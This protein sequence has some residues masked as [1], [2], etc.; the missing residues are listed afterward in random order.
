M[1]ADASTQRPRFVVLGDT[2]YG[3]CCVDEVAAAHISAD[4]IIHYGHACLSAP[5]SLP[6]LYVFDRHPVAVHAIAARVADAVAA[7]EAASSGSDGAA[8]AQSVLLLWEPAFSHAI[9][10]VLQAVGAL[11]GCGEEVNGAA[12]QGSSL[13]SAEVEAS[14]CGCAGAWT[15]PTVLRSPCPGRLIVPQYLT[16]TLPAK[17]GAA[18]A[19]ASST[20]SSSLCCGGVSGPAGA[21]PTSGAAA[22][23][24]AAGSSCHAAPSTAAASGGASAT[25]CCPCGPAAGTA[26]PD[27]SAGGDASQPAPVC[28]ASD[29]SSCC[30]ALSQLPAG[31]STCCGLHYDAGG[32]SVSQLRVLHLGVRPARMRAVMLQFAAAAELTFI[33]PCPG[34]VPAP[35]LA[36]D[37]PPAAEGT[38]AA[39][40]SASAA[41]S[42]SA[43]AAALPAPA[44]LPAPLVTGQLRRQINASYM[45]VEAVRNASIIGIVAGTLAV[46]GR[47]EVMAALRAAAKAAGKHAYTFVVGK[48]SAPKL[49]NFPEVDAFVL[50]ACPENS[51]LSAEQVRDHVKPV[52]TPQEALIG[53]GRD[54]DGGAAGDGDE[55]DG[56]AGDS[57]SAPSRTGVEWSGSGELDFK[58]LLALAQG[59]AV[60]GAGGSAGGGPKRRKGRAAAGPGGP[61]VTF[62]E[63]GI[64]SEGEGEAG[65]QE[66]DGE[67]GGGSSTSAAAASTALVHRPDLSSGALSTAVFTS[68]AAQYAINKRTWRGLQYETGEEHRLPP[69]TAGA[70][71]SGGSGVSGVSGAEGA[72][73][74]HAAGALLAAGGGAAAFDTRIREGQRGIASRYDGEGTG[75][76]AAAAANAAAA[77][78]AAAR[79]SAHT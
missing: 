47:N 43:A 1:S 66:E 23:A 10:A 30:G 2:S 53:L 12:G 56:D 72:I 44:I 18:A 36:A 68:P 19:A 37:R 65:E 74:P 4:G 52:V 7:A 9:P 6:V 40:A 39:A 8:T 71:G 59:E 27:A 3:A 34:G 76:A 41:A 13:R 77:A 5:A 28:R 70:S 61:S 51:L 25:P 48:L 42:P 79:A 69:A 60:R 26:A 62:G 58:R 29:A 38:E 73:V 50:V 55:G 75:A 21:P 67:G 16:A 54:A 33:D 11:R 31:L 45:H 46:A 63:D 22:S 35:S 64:D 17:R 57:S 20:S 78:A 49:G 15:R 24:R 32:V 14:G